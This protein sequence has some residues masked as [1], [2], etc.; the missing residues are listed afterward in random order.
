MSKNAR[1]NEEYAYIEGKFALLE[2]QI[3]EGCEFM[4]GW[5]DDSLDSEE[6][7]EVVKGDA[8]RPGTRIRFLSPRNLPEDVFALGLCYLA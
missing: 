8:I 4:R 3:R 5:L 2:E 6:L 1:G 7:Y